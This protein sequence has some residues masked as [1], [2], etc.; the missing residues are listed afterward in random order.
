MS[1]IWAAYNSMLSSQ[2]LLTKALTSLTGFTAGDVLAQKFVED[3]D[4]PYD[5]MRTIRLGSFGFLVHG[6]TGHYFYGM[7]D[8]KMPG[9][10]PVTVATKVAIDQT[11]WNPI[12]GCMFFGYLNLMEGKSFADYQNKLKADL[13]TAVMGSWAVWVPAHTINFAFIPPAQRLLY[14]NSIQIGYNV[15]LSFLGNKEV[16]TDE[17]KKE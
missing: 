9:T 8:S 17:P 10:K 13:K 6:T 4:K 1:A 12:F 11:I 14:I 2:P 15:F 5:I 3:A 16:E 7:L